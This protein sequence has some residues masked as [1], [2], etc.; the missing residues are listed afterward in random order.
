V[1]DWLP[2]FLV[3][4]LGREKAQVHLQHLDGV[5]IWSI[6]D[7]S[8]TTNQT[9][10]R[11]GCRGR[12][13]K[14]SSGLPVLGTSD[15]SWRR[16][17]LEDLRRIQSKEVRELPPLQYVERGAIIS[18]NGE[19]KFFVDPD[20]WFSSLG[21]DLF[22]HERS[23]SSKMMAGKLPPEHQPTL[24]QKW[25]K[26]AIFDKVSSR[27]GSESTVNGMFATIEIE[28]L[29]SYASRHSYASVMYQGGMPLY[30]IKESLKHKSIKTTEIYIKSLG[31]DE[32]S[33][34]EDDIFS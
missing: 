23:P 19:C 27:C 5:P 14:I 22:T 17:R 9:I 33:A 11:L 32:I 16:D 29:T 10:S 26:W 8:C 13:I 30:M 2:T 18:S 12:E 21:V 24:T 1:G 6:L 31:L 34:Y 20:N 4:A 15:G 28:N 3:L 7:G 25:Q